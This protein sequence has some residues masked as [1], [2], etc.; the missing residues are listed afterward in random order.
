MVTPIISALRWKEG[1]LCRRGALGRWRT[2]RLKSLA[3]FV[4]EGEG[5]TRGKF[6]R[7]KEFSRPQTVVLPVVQ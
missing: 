4:R 3:Y 2:Q 7:K 1:C 5:L 6:A